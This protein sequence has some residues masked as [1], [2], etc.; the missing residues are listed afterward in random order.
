MK[1]ARKP[2]K[3]GNQSDVPV[4]Y[5]CCGVDVTDTVGNHTVCFT[6]RVDAEDDS[7]KPFEG[8]LDLILPHNLPKNVKIP[9]ID[10]TH[11]TISW[12]S[13]TSVLIDDSFINQ[14][15]DKRLMYKIV[16]GYK[17]VVHGKAPAR[18]P[19]KKGND[20]GVHITSHTFFIDA[21]CLLIRGGRFK[22]ILSY[23]ATCTP[24]GYQSFKFTVSIDH[25]LLSD[26]QIRRH[27]PFVCYLKSIHQ[28]PDTPLSY[29]DLQTTCIGPYL[30][31]KFNNPSPVAMVTVPGLHGPDMKMNIA[32]FFWN[33]PPPSEMQIELHDRDIE[34]PE[35]NIIV[36]SSF[37][38]PE[39]PV[40]PTK[41]EPLSVEQI[42]GIKK[43]SVNSRPYGLVEAKI[44]PGR[45]LYPIQPIFTRDSLVQPGF[46]TES[47]TYMTIECESMKDCVPHIQTPT[48]ATPTTKNRSSVH[49]S[50]D[51]KAPLNKLHTMCS[52][53]VLISKNSGLSQNDKVFLSSIQ[54][55]IV[56]YNAKAFGQKDFACVPSMK[57]DKEESPAVSG[58]ILMTGT[59][60]I[61]II[62]MVSNSEADIGFHQII[63]GKS[64]DSLV[65][66]SKQVNKF[67]LPRLY[68]EFD[69]AV[70]K[71]KL[72]KPLEELL[73]DPSLYIQNSHLSDCFEIMN[74]LSQIQK[75]RSYDDFEKDDLWP[76]PTELE[77]LN[78]KKGSLL[79]LDELA[80][81]PRIAKPAVINRSATDNNNDISSEIQE[82]KY[83]PLNQDIIDSPPRDLEFFMNKNA[84]Y[85]ASL[86]KKRQL[87]RKIVQKSEDGEYEI[88]CVSNPDEAGKDGWVIEKPETHV[89]LAQMVNLDFYIKGMREV[90]GTEIRGDKPYN[91]FTGKKSVF[92]DSQLL[93]VDPNH[94]PWQKGDNSLATS[95]IRWL[96][97]IRGGSF[98]KFNTFVRPKECFAG[99]EF[100]EKGPYYDHHEEEKVFLTKSISRTSNFK[101]VVPASKKFNSLIR[102][103]PPTPPLSINE[104]YNPATQISRE[105]EQEQNTTK[106]KFKPFLSSSKIKKGTTDS[107]YVKKLVPTF[108]TPA[109]GF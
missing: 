38:Y 5:D 80:F 106:G 37:V 73:L 7:K 85:I 87:D 96:N 36:G 27:Q 35:L 20:K 102:D 61:I 60:D 97:D 48:L 1:G 59:Y 69:S 53:I 62:E 18:P 75:T 74:K 16:F 26:A 47:G 56:V 67:P 42:L 21:N 14:I 93:K 34:A 39:N 78:A 101:T 95:D 6:F 43:E 4:V 82:V 83:I 8:D 44:D 66:L 49:S 24:P 68:G 65:I 23:S 108:P 98:S 79:T 107:L 15:K 57:L 12:Q 71:F 89:P 2:G 31:I 11:P 109:P 50:R 3:G 51:D 29:L 77:M 70:K 30:S 55:R 84:E 92:V 105:V 76:T 28:L 10:V 64:N 9:K 58:F 90:N 104:P 17:A 46:Y 94:E 54:E 45:N 72:A 63:E 103:R 40:K 19:P 100:I 32:L 86:A 22:P 33:N 13:Q 41:V 91:P 99:Q 52:R 88:V 25:P 81:P